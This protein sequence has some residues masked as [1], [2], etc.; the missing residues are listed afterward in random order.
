LFDGFA[1]L[2]GL[3]PV[4]SFEAQ[5]AMALE[6]AVDPGE[7]G[8]YPFVLESQGSDDRADTAVP[9][10]VDWRPAVVALLDDLAR[11]TPLGVIAARFHNMLVDSI[12]SVA[13]KTGL[14]RIAISGGCFQN[15]ILTQR[16]LDR[17]RKER[18]EVLMQ[19]R[20]PANDGGISLGQVAV[21]A[22]SH[23]PGNSI[24]RRAHVPRRSG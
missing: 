18:F 15:R 4:T 12:V 3:H 13:K 7:D 8:S 21:A 5:A 22:A 10:Q 2:A 20:V 1:A 24:E 23:G 14:D 17:L 11:E 9:M 19:R 16:V 6:Y